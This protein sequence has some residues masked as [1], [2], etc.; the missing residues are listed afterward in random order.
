MKW[1]L[2]AMLLVSGFLFAACDSLD[3]G[4]RKIIINEAVCSDV[5]FL[6]MNLGEETE[7]IVDNTKHSETQENITVVLE[8]F[9]VTVT[10]EL[11]PG[12]Q[13][14]SD[15][16]TLRLSAPAGE[17][18]SVKVTPLFTGQFVGTCGLQIASGSG[19]TVLQQGLTFEIVNN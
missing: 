19:G 8:E 6:R 13:V 5:G 18:Q 12:S 4:P 11:P 10:G 1:F 15:F 17:E 3:G 7:I 2:G 16:T 14:G 9:P